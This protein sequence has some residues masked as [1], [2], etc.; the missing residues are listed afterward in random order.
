MTSG[1]LTI[2]MQ[3]MSHLEYGDSD[4]K[5]YMVVEAWAAGRLVCFYVV[6]LHEQERLS[7]G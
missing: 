6:D 3:V 4:A 5:P 7:G 1:Q 2:P